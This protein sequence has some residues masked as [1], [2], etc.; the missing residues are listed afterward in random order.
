MNITKAL[1][2]LF[3]HAHRLGW[4]EALHVIRLKKKGAG[5]L[6]EVHA[7]WLGGAVKVR[8]ATADMAT[9]DQFLLGPYMPATTGHAPSSI[10]DCGANMGLA[11]RYLKQAFPQAKV[12]AIEPDQ[13][14]FKLLS[15]N[16]SGLRDCH[17]VLAAVWPVPGFVQLERDGLRHSAFRTKATT[18]SGDTIEALSI[19]SIM[20]R[21]GLERIGLLKIDIEGA[22]MELFGAPDLS[23]LEKVD[24]IAIELHDLFKPGCG[25]AFFKAMAKADWTYRVY[26]EVVYCERIPTGHGSSTTAASSLADIPGHIAH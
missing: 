9:I 6:Q 22:E 17:P 19:P 13:E 10:V 15:E 3:E 8:P 26:G 2:H 7:P 12:I 1:Y 20:E 11:S 14:N 16:L 25:N 23:W 4:R 5:A 21:F 18:G 24:R